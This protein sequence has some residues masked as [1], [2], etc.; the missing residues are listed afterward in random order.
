[1]VRVA[2]PETRMIARGEKPSAE[3]RAMMVEPVGM[4]YFF[5]L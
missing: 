2:G 3:A 4:G 5:F 1:M